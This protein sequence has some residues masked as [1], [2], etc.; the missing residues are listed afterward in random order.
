MARPQ[1]AL[2]PLSPPC[3]YLGDAP[4]PPI[5]LLSLPRSSHVR[6]P[7]VFRPPSPPQR[8]LT[9]YAL[10]ISLVPLTATIA[11]G[12]QPCCGAHGTGGLLALLSHHGAHRLLM[13]RA[14]SRRSAPPSARVF[15]PRGPRLCP[16]SSL[17]RN[18][19]TVSLS[20]P[21]IFFVLPLASRGRAGRAAFHDSQI[22]ARPPFFLFHTCER[23]TQRHRRARA[24]ETPPQTTPPSAPKHALSRMTLSRRNQNRQLSNSSRSLF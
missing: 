22:A 15:W 16:P 17:C 1:P 7:L 6:R 2:A 8:P 10:I 4:L 5:C 21:S 11:A 9:P 12:Q 19:K 13:M 18:K 23:Y 20:L 3:D 14:P 24:L